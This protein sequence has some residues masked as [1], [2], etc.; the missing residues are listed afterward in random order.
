MRIAQWD[1]IEF[2]RN[3]EHVS[4]KW[5]EEYWPPLDVDTDEAAWNSSVERFFVDLDAAEEI[6]MD[7]GTDLYAPIP[8]ALEYTVFREMV[9]IADHN[10]Y[11]LGQLVLLKKSFL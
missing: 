2:I 9:L 5:P 8:H 10:S 1:I 6:L 4:P 7:P 3:P 11:H